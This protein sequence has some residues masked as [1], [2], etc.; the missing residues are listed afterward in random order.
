MEIL[1]LIGKKI[2]KLIDVKSIMTLTLTIIFSILAMNSVI[3]GQ[4]FLTIFTV[5]V[6]FYFGTQSSKND[7]N[8]G[9]EE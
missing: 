2:A 5:I 3:S 7:N 4:E 6:G 1:K 8:K 9:S